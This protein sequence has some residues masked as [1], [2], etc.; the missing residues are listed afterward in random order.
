MPPKAAEWG[1]ARLANWHAEL[2]G[3]SAPS[4]RPSV[5]RAWES[6]IFDRREEVLSLS[7]PDE[8]LVVEV[9]T[10]KYAL[11]CFCASA[12]PHSPCSLLGHSCFPGE[13]NNIAFSQPTAA[14]ALASCPKSL[15]TPLSVTPHPQRL[16][17]SLCRCWVFILP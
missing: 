17:P 16:L 10:F 9:D 7:C 14:S 6:C 5:P 13:N 1:S 15:L 8:R 12:T 2:G 4:S 11:E 3:R